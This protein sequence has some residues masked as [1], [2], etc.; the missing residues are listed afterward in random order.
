MRVILL[1]YLIMVYRFLVNV[2]I[3]QWKNSLSDWYRL[4]T[5]MKSFLAIVERPFGNIQPILKAFLRR[6]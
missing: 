5:R 1:G 4:I 3:Y 6:D 2:Y